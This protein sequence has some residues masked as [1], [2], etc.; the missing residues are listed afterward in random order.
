ME[1]GGGWNDSAK[2]VYTTGIAMSEGRDGTGEIKPA[3]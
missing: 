3:G 1:R 2:V